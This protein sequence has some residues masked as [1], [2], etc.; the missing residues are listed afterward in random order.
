MTFE[1]FPRSAAVATLTVVEETAS[2]NDDLLAVAAASEEFTVIA[3]GSQ[4]SGRGR[5][6]R[7][8]Q[9]PPGMTLAA[10][11]LLKPRLPAGE[12]VLVDRFGWLPLLAGL[13]MTRSISAVLPDATVSLKW[14][15]D[16]L[17]DG[18][19]VSGLLAELLP[20]LDGV[21]IGSGVNLSIPAEALPT[22]VSTSIGLHNPELDG[23]ALADAVLGGYL[24]QLR[25]LYG[26]YLDAGA[27]AAASGLLAEVTAAC[28]SIG[29]PV[30][31]ELPDGSTMHGVAVSLD[32]SGR[33]LVKRSGDDALQ[34]VAA[35]DVTHLRYE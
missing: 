24:E 11:V 19:K 12:G 10:S 31:V 22:P 1:D 4:T 2:T 3:T 7:V 8:W 16:V 20:T 23:D 17:V 32:V 5:L 29:Q 35:G 15:N 25:E 21:I 26:R 9:A 18:K 6:G 14:P 33:L 28:G 13:A 34:A 30:R 27:D